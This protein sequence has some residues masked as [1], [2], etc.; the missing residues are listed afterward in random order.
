MHSRSDKPNLELI[1]KV[2]GREP[3]LP[4]PK[5]VFHTQSRNPDVLNHPPEYYHQGY[6]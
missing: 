4:L 3:H 6:K 1:K 5:Q 2:S